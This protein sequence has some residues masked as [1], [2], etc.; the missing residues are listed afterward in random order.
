[1]AG[2]SILDVEDAIIEALGPLKVTADPAG[3]IRTIKSY[4]GELGKKEE[5]EDL[6]K[7][8]KGIT[9]AAMVIY[10]GSQSETV[11]QQVRE[12]MFFGLICVD[13]SLR[14][15]ESAR[16]GS[17]TNSGVYEVISQVNGILECNMLGLDILPLEWQS[18]DPLY[19]DTSL[20]IYTLLYKT[21]QSYVKEVTR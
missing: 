18:T 20:A 9:P 11:N 7:K 8:I 15:V 17:T 12:T 21:E 2:Y 1:M 3:I 19:F 16:R 13:E 5:S 6:I 4:Q 10:A 14:G